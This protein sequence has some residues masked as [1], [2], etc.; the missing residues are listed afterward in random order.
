MLL[1]FEKALRQHAG[2]QDYAS[3]GLRSDVPTTLQ[4]NIGLQCNLACKHCHVESSPRRTKHDENLSQATADRVVDWLRLHHKTVQMLDLTGGSPE[5]NPNFQS[6]VRAAS[7][8]GMSVIDRCNPTI[9][10]HQR[11]GQDYGWIPAF[12]AK[13]HVHVHASL[14][15]YLPENVRR[16]RGVHAFDDSIEGLR[17]LNE[18]G[19]GIEASLPLTLVYNPTGPKLPPP[20]EALED[21]YRRVLREQFDLS[22]TRLITITNMPIARWRDHLSRNDKLDQYEQLLADSFNSTTVEHLM[23]RHQIHIDSNGQVHDCD[24]N[25]AMGMIASIEHDRSRRYL[26]DFTPEELTGRR[27]ATGSHCFGCTAGSGS[28]CGGSLVAENAT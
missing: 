4:I 18:V 16:Q 27:I 24:F 21:D 10:V 28:G 3:I 11:G 25:F 1:S 26:W 13:H 9:I 14:P 20:A 15:C 19:Y 17:K 8:L 2:N 5:M 7:G 12:L 23:C 6:L 22:F